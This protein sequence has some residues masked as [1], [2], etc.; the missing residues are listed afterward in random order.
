MLPLLASVVFVF[1]R[2]YW[3]F[4]EGIYFLPGEFL[5][6]KT[7]A[8]NRSAILRIGQESLTAHPSVISEN[9]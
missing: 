5:V 7:G 2:L 9:F 4:F 6:F 1:V 8:L 3:P